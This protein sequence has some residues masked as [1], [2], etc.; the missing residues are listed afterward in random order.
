M[1]HS[2]IPPDP[3]KDVIAFLA[4]RLRATQTIVTHISTVLLSQ[5]RVYKLKRS[6]HLPYLDF[7]TP[8]LRAAMCAREVAL[9]RRFA[10]ALYLGLR[11]VTREADGNLTLDGSGAFVES[12]VEMRRFPDD[13]LF[14]D[15]ARERRLTKEMIERLARRIAA[16]HEAAAPDFARGGAASMRAIIESMETSLR[17]A[18]P[19]PMEEIDAHLAALRR[20]LAENAA[21]IDARRQA[22]KVRPCH[23]DLNL[24]NVCLF[25]GEP[26]PF[27]CIEF[28]DDISTI[29]V[30][31]DLAFLL[32]DLWR[33]GLPALA[34]LALNRYLDARKEKEE[35]GLPLLALFMS[36]RAAIRAH[37]EASQQ[38]ADVARDYFNLSR[39]LLAPAQGVVIAI[40]GFSGSGKSSAAAALAPLLTPAPGARIFNSDRLRKE[41][42]GAAS[43]DRLPPKAYRSDVSEKVYREMFDAA[44]RVAKIGWPVVVDAV[45]DR[46]ED[47]AAIEA[48]AQMAGAPFFGFWLDLDLP[49]RLARVDARVNDVSDA[50][51]E[52]L[53]A[54]M[55]KE[56][57]EIA[58]L[59][60]N[61]GREPQKTADEIIANL[62]PSLRA[63]FSKSGIPDF[64][65][66]RSNPEP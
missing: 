66:V 12:V 52:V 47:R 9:N 5:D 42:F 1:T 28:S 59:R 16:A 44:E 65:K 58:W 46:P 51:R 54:Q 61:A 19:A 53:Q 41:L 50:T 24:R 8:E 35:E 2:P 22:G 49:Q 27:D 40:G 29:D 32:M 17:Q 25:E 37:V 4:T 13:A 38:H 10:P 34:N 21:L 23:G 60:V 45:F 18:P 14:D 6:V 36:L 33:V 55:T 63:F 43:T 11:C 56:T 57:G 26:T 3:Q 20:A 31:Y 15:M 48:A 30:L 39:A 7:S 64:A 62:A